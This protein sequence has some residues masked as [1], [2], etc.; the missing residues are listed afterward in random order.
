[1]NEKKVIFVST[2]ST[3][4]EGTIQLNFRILF[5]NKPWII[6]NLL[7]PIVW[8][9]VSAILGVRLAAENNIVVLNYSFENTTISLAWFFLLIGYTLCFLL[10]FLSVRMLE[11]KRWYLDE[12]K[13]IAVFICDDKAFSFE[14]AR[15]TFKL[16]AT[17]NTFILGIS[18]LCSLIL[19]LVLATAGF[20]LFDRNFRDPDVQLNSHNGALYDSVNFLT[21]QPLVAW[22]L[23]GCFL[24]FL[25]Y[26][27]S[28]LWF[29]PNL[30][31]NNDS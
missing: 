18:F 16:V 21:L 5:E 7:V 28:S 29:V 1:M 8:C 15:S 23:G 13:N 27:Y 4:P 30:P 24:A 26:Y 6:I 9:T 19:G 14:N 2:K 20:F 12:K 22:F 17:W 31:K 11:T 10:P 25:V 3:L